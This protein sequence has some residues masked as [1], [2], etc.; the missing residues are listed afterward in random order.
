MNLLKKFSDPRVIAKT[1]LVTVF[2]LEF[3]NVGQIYRM[4]HEH[5]AAGQ[6]VTSWVSVLLALVLW[7]N[8]YRV[9]CPKEKFAFWATAVGIG[10]N[11]TVIGT[12]VRFR[13]F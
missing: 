5:T 10:M 9:C 13:Y 11:M 7:L 8:F 3:A 12:V 2:L 6:N 4:W 1:P